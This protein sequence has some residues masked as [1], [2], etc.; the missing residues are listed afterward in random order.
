MD[1]IFTVDLTSIAYGSTHIKTTLSLL[2]DEDRYVPWITIGEVRILRLDGRDEWILSAE[3][4]DHSTDETHDNIKILALR[5]CGVTFKNVMHH[6]CVYLVGTICAEESN[7]FRVP[8][9][10]Y[11]PKAQRNS[12]TCVTCDEHHP[13]IPGA[14][15]PPKN[16]ELFERLKGRKVEIS[17]R[18]LSKDPV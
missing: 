4:A 7:D 8:P 17:I 1:P 13:L 10:G 6:G 2:N 5:L 14:H 12:I 16:P 11:E 3:A 9:P 18:T 15:M